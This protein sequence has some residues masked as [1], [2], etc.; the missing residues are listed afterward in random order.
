M[1]GA[2][3]AWEFEDHD[4]SSDA[5]SVCH[6]GSYL[7][8]DDVC[9]TPNLQMDEDRDGVGITKSNAGENYASVGNP[10][11]EPEDQIKLVDY[12]HLLHDRVHL[13][14]KEV[15]VGLPFQLSD[16]QMLSLH[17]LGSGKN[18]L[19]VSPPGSGKMTVIERAALLMKKIQGKENGVA[20]VTEPLT[21]IMDERLS[22]SMLPTGIIS[23]G[24]GTADKS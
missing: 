6:L 13:A 12:P 1:G 14:I 7:E 3:Q 5:S 22:S 2:Q 8:S 18:L 17:V 19:L 10:V 21:Q 15:E 20:I 11:Q 16:F 9:G 23:M 4:L 24:G